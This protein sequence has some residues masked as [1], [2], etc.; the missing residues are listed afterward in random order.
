LQLH[1]NDWLVRH[2][3]RLLQE[4]HAA[5]KLDASTPGRLLEMLAGNAD[6]TRQLR[7][8]WALHA[9][10]GLG[11]PQLLQL[12]ASPNQY[13]RAWAIQ[14]EL[15]DREASPEMLRRLTALAKS[16]STPWVRLALAAGLQ[17]LPLDDRWP[18]ATALVRPSED[19]SD[20]NLPLM[21]WYGVEPLVAAD[22]RRGLELAMSCRIPVVSKYIARRAGEEEAGL[23]LVVETL[24]RTSDAGMQV[25]LL[26]GAIEA[27]H[28]HR[29]VAM[30]AS[31]SAAYGKLS[32][33]SDQEVRRGAMAL[34]VIFNDRGAIATLHKL[35]AD[36]SATAA[37][38]GWAIERLLDARDPQLVDLLEPLVVNEGLSGLA[39]RGLAVFDS[40]KTPPLLL[41][42][43]GRLGEAEQRDAVNTLCARPQW[44]LAL[45]K[46]V[47][48]GDL[49]RT[50][51]S[52][53]QV[54]QL[55]GFGNAEVSA[56]LERVWGAVREST[57]DKQAQLQA[58]RSRLPNDRL[59]SADRGHGR[60]VFSRVCSNCHTL[61]DAGG[62][63][64]PNL[65]GSQRAN[66]DYVLSNVLDP[67]AVVSKQYQMVILQT[68]DGRVLNGIIKQEDD[69]T[70][71][72]QTTNEIVTLAKDE[73]DVRKPT[74]VSMMPEGMLTPLS[75][76]ELRDLI[77]YLA[78][79][80]QV[81]LPPSAKDGK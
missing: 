16:E 10:G 60:A 43:Y 41:A 61:F 67:N 63:V 7:A 31:W 4:R 40:P 74:T 48:R 9:T 75:D 36:S 17:R 23:A 13:L 18:I 19:A 2:A 33:S 30:P 52:S 12:L 62:S 69:L 42:A 11:E 49:P 5:G 44:A 14:L 79:P 51:I 76:D 45:L 29:Q 65:T 77:A 35:V 39:I 58:Y 46:A 55:A 22:A 8:L 27:L 34:A 57:A 20:P 37:D 21:L 38:R 78:S 28:G 24:G 81:P 1:P 15:E 50:A 59:Q 54:R 71:A 26:G 72:L 73:I 32:P 64:G 56:E 66:L 70:L 53:E 3:R 25:Q 68:T 6:P 47:D 80:E